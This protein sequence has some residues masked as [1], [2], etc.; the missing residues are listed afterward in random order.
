[1]LKQPQ[2]APLGVEYQVIIIY[3]AVKKYLL[4]IA[5]E[6]VT[7]FEHGLFEYIDSKYPEIPKSIRETKE[8]TDDTEKALV[9]AIEEYKQK[10]ANE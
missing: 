10:F 3:A 9:K 4:D 8:I 2:Y 6:S 1:M 7:T 5:V